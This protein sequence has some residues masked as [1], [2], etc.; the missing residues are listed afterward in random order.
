MILQEHFLWGEKAKKDDITT[1]IL[2]HILIITSF[3][4]Q[5]IFFLHFFLCWLFMSR[6][7]LFTSCI[8]YIF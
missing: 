3:P 2:T 1:I 6:K 4:S 5:K 7:Y 8:K